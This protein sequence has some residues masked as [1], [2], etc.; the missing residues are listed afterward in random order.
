MTE[1]GAGEKI[2]AGAATVGVLVV[3]GLLG[4][5]IDKHIGLVPFVAGVAKLVF[6]I[7]VGVATCYVIGAGWWRLG[8]WIDEREES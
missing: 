5:T 8:E 7:V 6:G 2:F 3:L 1:P 4:L